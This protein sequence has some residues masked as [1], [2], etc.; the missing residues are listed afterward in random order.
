MAAVIAA[1]TLDNLH[2]TDTHMPA[3]AITRLTSELYTA[4]RKEDWHLCKNILTNAMLA[5]EADREALDTTLFDIFGTVVQ[6]ASSAQCCSLVQLYLQLVSD[7]CSSREVLTLLM[8]SLDNTS[9]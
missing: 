6:C 1:Q 9:G 8:S 4:Q 3:V 5:F 7:H 2:S